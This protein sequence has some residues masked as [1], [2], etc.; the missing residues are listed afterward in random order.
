MIRWKFWHR[1][2]NGSPAALVHTPELNHKRYTV[3][4]IAP[5]RFTWYSDDVYLPLK[6]TSDPGPM[7]IV[8]PLLKPGVTRAPANEA[9]QPALEAMAHETPKRFPAL[10]HLKER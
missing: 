3:V 4:G 10:I 7:Y 6:L 8:M 5:S 9:L 1:H 2:F